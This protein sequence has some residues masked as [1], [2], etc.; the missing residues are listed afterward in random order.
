MSTRVRSSAASEVYQRQVHERF[1]V[2]DP[3]ARMLRFHTQT[4]GS[5][6]TSQQPVNNVVRVTMQALAAVMGGTQSL[7]TNSMD[8]ALGLPTETSARTALRTQQILAHETGV[9]D[10]IDPLG[11]APFV[12]ALTDEVEEAARA[13]IAK[14]DEMG[15]AEAAIEQG[16]YQNEIH[17]SAMEWQRGVESGSQVVVGVNAYEVEEGKPE[18]FRVDEAMQQETLDDLE[19]LRRVRDGAAVETSLN[20]LESAARGDDNLMPLIL[21]CVENLATVGEICG[22]LENVFG[23]YVPGTSF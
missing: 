12:E 19:E 3:K 7:H 9:A 20:R 16:F 18:V 22:R 21:D 23:K 8:E 2:T 4:A 1:G 6:L 5:M 17:R 10:V 15:G 13:L 14:V 11:G